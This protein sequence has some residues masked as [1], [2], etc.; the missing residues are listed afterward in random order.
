MDNVLIADS[1]VFSFIITTLSSILL[2]FYLILN[3]QIAKTI[4][5]KLHINFRIDTINNIFICIF[6]FI[7]IWINKENILIKFHVVPLQIFTILLLMIFA[8][9][10]SIYIF[11][12]TKN[13]LSNAFIE[14]SFESTTQNFI[15]DS[16]LFISTFA[17]TYTFVNVEL[18]LF[19]FL[20]K[21]LL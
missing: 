3:E 15:L 19:I 4:K 20:G 10:F 14:E 17:L 21:I 5:E 11:I 2:A 12:T 8:L 6:F 18:S 9:L 16:I 13:D 7:T 1:T